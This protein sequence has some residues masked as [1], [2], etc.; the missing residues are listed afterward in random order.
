MA[1]EGMTGNEDQRADSKILQR[2]LLVPGKRGVCYTMRD[3]GKPGSWIDTVPLIIGLNVYWNYNWGL[4]YDSTRQPTGVMFVPQLW[5]GSNTNETFAEYITKICNIQELYNNG[6][7]THLLGFNEP[8]SANQANM[9]VDLA[10]ERWNVL[11]TILHHIPL[12]SPSCVHADRLWMQEF[13]IKIKENSL[14][15]DGIG[16][17]WYGPPN[18]IN[19]KNCMESIYQLYNKE[20]PLYITEFAVADWDAKTIDTNKYTS[21]RVFEFMKMILP[22]LEQTEYIISYSWFPF[23]IDSIAG[24]IS[25]LYDTNNQLTKCGQYYKSITN[26]NINGDG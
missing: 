9:S 15:M 26:E 19:F 2:P 22:W 11:N 25:A 12:I 5:N 4:M 17:H 6:T 1:T 18:V 21:E 3:E 7:I 13:V 10:I 23:N 24:G 8:D 14:R 20:Y 16:V